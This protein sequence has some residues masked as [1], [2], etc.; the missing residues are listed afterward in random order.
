ME[1]TNLGNLIEKALKQIEEDKE[2][3]ALSDADAADDDEAFEAAL[4]DE[5]KTIVE[6]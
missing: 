4:F 3:E 2:K 6:D 1:E 5:H